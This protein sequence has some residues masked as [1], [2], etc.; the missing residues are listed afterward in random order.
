MCANFDLNEKV[1]IFMILIMMLINM[2]LLIEVYQKRVLE[3]YFA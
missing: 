3:L 1:I 2:F